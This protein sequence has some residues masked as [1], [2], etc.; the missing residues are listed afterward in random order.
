MEE[1]EITEKPL[2]FKSRKELNKEKI[3]KNKNIFLTMLILLIPLAI[4]NVIK[5]LHD[6]I[7]ALLVAKAYSADEALK[8]SAIAALDIH[9]P[10]FGVFIALGT[11]LSFAIVGMVGQYVGAKK[12]DL[13]K[14]YAS[15]FIFIS[16]ALGLILT[17]IFFLTSNVVWGKNIIAYLM[18]ARGETLNFA[19][20]YF[21]IRGFE[22][23]F[24]FFFMSY[25][26]IRQATGE[27]VL[28]VILNISAVIS[29][30]VLTYILVII[31]NFG[32]NGAA[33]ATVISQIMICPIAL[34]D[35]FKSK[36]GITI[37]VKDL[38]PSQK[39]FVEIAKIAVP[40]SLGAMVS[41]LGFGVIKG[42]TLSYGDH[43][44][45]AFSAGNRISSFLTNFLNAITQ[46]M[47]LF[48]SINIGNKNEKRAKRS[49]LL[50]TI[51]SFS[52]MVFFC[53]IVIP[54]RIP[55]IK[56]I[57]SVDDSSS[58]LKLSATY[59]VWLIGTQ[60]LMGLFQSYC[61]LFN[62]SANSK[63]SLMMELFRLWI[64]RIP[65]LVFYVLVIDRSLKNP[66][67]IAYI[68]MASNILI[69]IV[70]EILKRKVNYEVKVKLGNS[71]A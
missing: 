31:F 22:F 59:A 18:G 28:P 67:G 36:K 38:I 14:K 65:F 26:A 41:Q 7:D 58:V 19:N 62:G 5:S 53:I 44:S 23:V 49:Y 33:I 24:V 40:A 43:V 10:T 11:G 21:F 16:V 47:A 66:M 30:I 1:L 37:S 51:L 39:E 15:K 35:L 48:I 25:V 29:N 52:S 32:P 46:V 45:T 57:L 2:K 6:M 63:Y 54:L 8:N 3:L 68:M 27:T 9:W 71:L 20:G 34:I 12:M 56:M 60:P 4:N 50:G 13:A 17:L 69:I 70:G 61:G 64:F 55:I 42:I